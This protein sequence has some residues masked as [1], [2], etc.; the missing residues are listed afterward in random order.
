MF[1]GMLLF[2][3]FISLYVINKPHNNVLFLEFILLVLHLTARPAVLVN[4][5]HLV[6]VTF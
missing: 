3:L 1:V 2:F 5:K 4:L 6:Q